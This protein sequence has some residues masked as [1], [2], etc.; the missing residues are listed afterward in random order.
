[1]KKLAYI[2]VLI[3]AFI[4]SGCENYFGDKTDISFIDIPEYS[5]RIAAYVPVQPIVEDF[6]RPTDVASGFDELVY[7]V[8]N[9]TEEI[10]A[11]DQSVKELGRFSVPGVTSVAQDRKLNLLAIGTTD[12]IINGLPL[13][14]TCIYRIS[15]V[16]PSGSYGIR[17]AR[18]I[19]KI[20]HPF[21]FKNTFSSSDQFVV[22]K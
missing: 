9:G 19:K 3:A 4:F 18:I 8:D 17:N 13:E 15:L 16:S 14:L 6:I 10:I 7:V 2:P 12:T 5:S 22:F 21:Y 11:Y 1:M 20:T